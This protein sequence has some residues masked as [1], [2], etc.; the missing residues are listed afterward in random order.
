MAS[1]PL[2]AMINGEK[3][4]KCNDE[5]TGKKRQQGEEER[6]ENITK[7][8][9][10]EQSAQHGKQATAITTNTETTKKPSLSGKH[11][12]SYNIEFAYYIMCIWM[13]EKHLLGRF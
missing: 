12:K 8:K 2:W 3:C 13:N 9:P 10:C 6:T 4:R 5:E 7:K 1:G 11:T